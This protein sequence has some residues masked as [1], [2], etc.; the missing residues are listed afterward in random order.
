[1][2]IAFESTDELEQLRTRLRKMSERVDA[3]RQRREKSVSGPEMPSSAPTEGYFNFS[4]SPS[5]TMLPEGNCYV[6]RAQKIVTCIV[7]LSTVEAAKTCA[8]LSGTNAE[9]LAA[10]IFRAHSKAFGPR[11]FVKA[12]TSS[13]AAPWFGMI[14]RPSPLF[15]PHLSGRLQ[16]R[17]S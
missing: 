9:T 17:Q 4:L 11:P 1:M 2:S 5:S 10:N 8:I 13:R 12:L 16:L 15:R 3:F 6:A 7:S 14:S